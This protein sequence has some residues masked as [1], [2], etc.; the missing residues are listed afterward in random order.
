MPVI[1]R[2]MGT[3]IFD[4]SQLLGTDDIPEVEKIAALLKKMS[5]S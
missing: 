5:W 3:R 1:A 4:L 2:S